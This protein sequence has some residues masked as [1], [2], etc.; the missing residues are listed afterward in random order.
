MTVE[1]A[2][3]A[4]QIEQAAWTCQ[5]SMQLT[6][7]MLP[8]A[9]TSEMEQCM[10]CERRNAS[11]RNGPLDIAA[12]IHLPVGFD[13]AERYPALVI[14]TPG[15][16]VKEQ[17]GRTYGEKLAERGFVTLV[18]DPSYQGRS[19][20]EP[21]DLEDPYVPFSTPPSRLVPTALLIPEVPAGIR[22]SRHT[23]RHISAATNKIQSAMQ[24][25]R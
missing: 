22:P 21:R 14:V 9:A 25:L 20:G 15:S 12:D 13:E 4:A 10:T 19:G 8:A 3:G 1:A 18:F 16:S 2:T 11:F 7:R 6:G 24:I 23:Q 17:I 5:S